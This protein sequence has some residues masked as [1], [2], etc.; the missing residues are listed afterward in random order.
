[1]GEEKTQAEMLLNDFFVAKNYGFLTGSRA[2]GC[3]TSISDYDIVTTVPVLQQLEMPDGQP[4]PIDQFI[5][6]HSELSGQ[7]ISVMDS[8]YQ[9][10]KHYYFRDMSVANIIPVRTVLIPSWIFA[11]NALILYTRQ[12]DKLTQLRGGIQY[13]PS[14]EA[15]VALFEQLRASFRL[16]DGDRRLLSLDMQTLIAQQNKGELDG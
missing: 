9:N 7:V 5:E 1:M 6:N 8:L 10:G 3:E 2:F 13:L 4:T 16:A 11:T 15:R 14:K 12:S